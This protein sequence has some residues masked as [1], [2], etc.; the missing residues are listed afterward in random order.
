MMKV[1]KIINKKVPE[2]NATDRHCLGKIK[3]DTKLIVEKP[4]EQCV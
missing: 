3:F 2:E 1:E 4:Y